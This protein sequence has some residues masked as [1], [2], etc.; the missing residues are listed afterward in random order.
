[1]EIAHEIVGPLAVSAYSDMALRAHHQEVVLLVYQ[2]TVAVG[3]F[4]PSVEGDHPVLPMALALPDA[5][6]RAKALEGAVVVYQSTIRD[7]AQSELSSGQVG[8]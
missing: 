4:H 3:S 8:A 7:G 5:A 1:M 6:G 2:L